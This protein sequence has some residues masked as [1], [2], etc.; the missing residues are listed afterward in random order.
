M[1]TVIAHEI[2]P[3][4]AAAPP[5]A[6]RLPWRTQGLLLLAGMLALLL[7]LGGARA[8]VE[9]GRLAWV[10]LCGRSVTAQVTAIEMTG[11]AVQGQP[12]QQTGLSYRYRDPFTGRI[13]TQHARIAA[14]EAGSDGVMPGLGAPAKSVV[15]PVIPVG[16]RLTLRVAG[17][18]EHP[19][20]YFWTPAPWGKGLFLTLCGLVVM[21]VSVRLLVVLARWRRLRA[22]LLLAGQAVIGTIIHKHSEVG[23]TPQY[24]LRYGYATVG[25]AQPCEHEEQVNFEQWK[26]FEIGQPVTVLYDPDA[27]SSAGM[28]ALMK[29]G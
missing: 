26:R 27:P 11:S 5:R 2:E 18:P 24:F 14:P 15:P 1:E 3:E 22:R 28:Y 8:L 7:F 6:A 25:N 19:L 21:G 23:D 12:A 10:A 13:V 29:Q 16:A 4:I 17:G 20:V 9:A